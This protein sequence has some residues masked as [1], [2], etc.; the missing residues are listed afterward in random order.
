MK[1]DDADEGKLELVDEANADAAA[2]REDSDPGERN[3][4]LGDE[5]RSTG[6]LDLFELVPMDRF[7]KQ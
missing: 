2:V 1:N 3:R 4:P 5:D 7:S 6:P